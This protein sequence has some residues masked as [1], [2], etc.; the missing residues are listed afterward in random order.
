MDTTSP[1]PATTIDPKVQAVAQD[2]LDAVAIG[3][4]VIAA[5]KSGGAAGAAALL[6]KVVAAAEKD[7]TDA[8]AAMPLI[9]AG[10]K[11]TEFWLPVAATLIGGAYFAVTG[12]DIP[13]NLGVCV[14]A[15]LSIYT[16]AR[17]LLKA[18]TAAPVPVPAPAK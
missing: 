9:K 7:F 16:V 6:P 11:T 4:Q 14:G 5:Y 13:V 17:T 15:L 3:K 12:K 1:T 2:A 10:Y 8:Q 18:K